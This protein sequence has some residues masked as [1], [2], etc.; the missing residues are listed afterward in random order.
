LLSTH[1]ELATNQEE[2][3]V[4]REKEETAQGVDRTKRGL[5]RVARKPLRSEFEILAALL[6]GASQNGGEPLSALRQSAN[7]SRR[8]AAKYVRFLVECGL[9]LEEDA[10]PDRL[11]VKKIYRPTEDGY[12]F[13]LSE[14]ELVMLVSPEEELDQYL[15]NFWR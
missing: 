6:R 13:I 14:K 1:P 7:L 2:A 12:K 15:L 11:N 10:P 9:L 4:V 5:H 8:I 3:K